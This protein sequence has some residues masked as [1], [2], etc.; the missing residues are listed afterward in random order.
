MNAKILAAS[1][2][3]AMFALMGAAAAQTSAVATTDLNVRSGPGPQYPVVGQIGASQSVVL[4]GC[5]QGSKWCA[6]TVNGA[7][8]WVYSDYLSS[9]F[10][11]KT[12][13]LTERP[14]DAV[15]NVVYKEEGGN[16]GKGGA[17]AGAGTGAVAGA[18]IGGPVGAAVGGVAGAV[19]GGAAGTAVKEPPKEVR[20][21]VTEQKAEPVYLDGEVVVGAG[22]P[23]N[24]EI[25]EVPNYE[26]RYANINGQPVLIDPG[27]RKIVYV[28]R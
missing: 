12:V 10:G 16:Q 28:Y 22:V 2:A 11:G 18:L 25:R 26:Y 13:V 19:V 17:L 21:Y 3:A 7:Q 6:T 15:P 8:G 20:T 23:E 27:S 4:D 14:A 9:D 5:A 24:V 1:T